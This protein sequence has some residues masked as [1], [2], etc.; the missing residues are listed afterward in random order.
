[1]DV[2]FWKDWGA[3]SRDPLLR[4]RERIQP[5]YNKLHHKH[6][7]ISHTIRAYFVLLSKRQKLKRKRKKFPLLGGWNK[8]LL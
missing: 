2:A 8:F 7:E 6:G 4:L 1:M 5:V 3:T